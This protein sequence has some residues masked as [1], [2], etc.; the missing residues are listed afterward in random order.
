MRNEREK[1]ENRKKKREV[2]RE[3]GDRES[4]RIG[5]GRGR[6]YPVS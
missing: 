2:G 3:R 6:G 1:K 5:L 4:E